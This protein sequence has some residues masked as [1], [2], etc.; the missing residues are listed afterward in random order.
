MYLEYMLLAVIL[1]VA[2]ALQCQWGKFG[3]NCER[4][5]SC[6]CALVK[7][8][9]AKHCRKSTGE[10]SEGCIPGSYGID[11]T[12]NCSENCLN[13][14]CNQHNGHCTQ[15][16]IENYKGVFCNISKD[17][18][19]PDTCTRNSAQPTSV[20]ILG[21]CLGFSVL[22]NII[23]CVR[24][25][26]VSFRRRLKTSKG[27]RNPNKESENQKHEHCIPLQDVTST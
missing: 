23:L 9:T 8:S 14:I 19:N 1:F 12:K 10:C 13:K 26:V 5:C 15:G 17:F 20:V 16:C 25:C 2:S 4:N 27:R 11:C 3:D 18:S 21:S 24:C 22:L 6:H 7:N